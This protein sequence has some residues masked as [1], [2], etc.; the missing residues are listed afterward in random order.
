[1]P[2][3]TSYISGGLLFTPKTLNNYLSN[4]ADRDGKLKVK[5]TRHDQAIDLLLVQGRR[6]VH[7]YALNMEDHLYFLKYPID[8][9]EYAS[10]FSRL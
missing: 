10:Y 8:S 1:M 4:R 2:P 3:T 7:I 9:I 6:A 5:E